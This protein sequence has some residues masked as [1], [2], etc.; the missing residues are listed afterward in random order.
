[1]AYPTRF[2]RLVVS[3]T[4]YETDIFSWSLAFAPNFPD[5]P[6]APPDEVPQGVIDAITAFH[7]TSLHASEARLTM[8]KL[9]EIGTDGRYTNQGD[10]V[11]HEFETPVRGVSANTPAPQTSLAI[12]LRTNK[13]RGRAHA[14]R[15]YTP[16]PG[17]SLVK[18]MLSPAD[19]QSAVNTAT[20][21]LEAVTAALPDGYAPAVMSD[22]GTGESE[23]VRYVAVGRVLDTIRSRRNAFTEEYLDGPL[24]GA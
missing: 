23:I 11:L 1:M 8:I 17:Y 7:N 4:L 19:Q 6:L 16:L 24:L 2:L 10:T 20:T 9:N 15:F 18:G 13:R 22:L 21:M 14:G 3:G 12:T 5:G